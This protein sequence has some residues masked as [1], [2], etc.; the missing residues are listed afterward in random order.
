MSSP[1]GERPA[2]ERQA[3]ER[4]VVVRLDDVALCYR[5]AKQRH[6]SVKDFA[7]HWMK[8]ALTYEQ[9]WALRG[10]DLEVTRGE[11]LAIIGRNGA[12]K[13]SLLKVI[14]GVLEPTRG[15]VET[16]GRLA[17]ILEL[18]TGFDHEL[19]G[20]ENVYLNAL[21]LGHSR[22]EI[23]ER[24]DEI[25]AFSELGDFVRSPIRSY[26]S[27]MLA[28]LGFSIATAWR[29]DVLILDEV[30]AVGDAHFIHKSRQRL[31]ELRATGTSI[32]LVSHDLKAVR[33]MSERCIWIDGGRIAA[34]GPVDEIV[35]RYEAATA[36]EEAESLTVEAGPTA[37]PAVP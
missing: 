7:I 1:A 11:R 32:L 4:Q 33:Q 20:L 16:R 34:E 19:T 30:L 14:S 22:K 18:G 26:S 3:G 23:E 31:R 8:R 21:L 17:P 25:V 37:S 24:I 12:G 10:V 6:S 36:S 15:R 28:R 13:S 29:P 5:L 35:D 2:G 9:L 27:G